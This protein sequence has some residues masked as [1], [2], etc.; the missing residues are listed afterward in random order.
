MEEIDV[1]AGILDTDAM[2][3]YVLVYSNSVVEEDAT[4]GVATVIEEPWWTW[5]KR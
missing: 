2:M 4:S 5:E 1:V 3:V